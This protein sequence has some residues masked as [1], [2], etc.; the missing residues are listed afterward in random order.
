MAQRFQDIVD[1]WWNVCFRQHGP[2]FN[3][4]A[5][6]LNVYFMIAKF[7]LKILERS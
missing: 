6:G 3:A 2:S 1:Y 7:R 4:L 5:W